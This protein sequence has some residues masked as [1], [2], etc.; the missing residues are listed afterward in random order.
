MIQ[1][2]PLPPLPGAIA[3]PLAAFILA[4]AMAVRTF[5]F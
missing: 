4:L 3:L 1:P 5:F 2:D